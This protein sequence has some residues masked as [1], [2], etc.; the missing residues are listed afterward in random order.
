MNLKPVSQNHSSSGIPLPRNMST[1]SKQNAKCLSGSLVGPPG[2][3]QQGGRIT[4][5][6]SSSSNTGSISNSKDLLKEASSRLQFQQQKFAAPRASLDHFIGSRSAYSSPQIPK[7]NIPHSKDTLDLRRGSLP[8]ETLGDLARTGN[9]NW[10]SGQISFRSLDNG[11]VLPPSR[12]QGFQGRTKEGLPHLKTTNG[13]LIWG[14]PSGH[15]QAMNKQRSK[16]TNGGTTETEVMSY[17]PTAQNTRA[18]IINSGGSESP[19]MAAVA[20]FRFRYHK[21][22]YTQTIAHTI[23]SLM[24]S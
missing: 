2:Q 18:A 14:T 23:K 1:F 12:L 7:R 10:R 3:F 17:K 19:R 5:F 20:P 8:H 6:S 9:K 15:Q 11:D 4:P 24:Q 22:V 13:N 21:W 16:F